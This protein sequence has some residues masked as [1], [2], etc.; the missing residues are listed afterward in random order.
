MLKNQLNHFENSENFE[1][2]NL[3]GFQLKD[4]LLLEEYENQSDEE[5][6]IKTFVRIDNDKVKYFLSQIKTSKFNSENIRKIKRLNHKNILQPLN[7]LLQDN[8]VFIG[9]EFCSISLKNYV[10]TTHPQIEIRLN[11]FSQFLKLVI[12]FIEEKIDFTSADLK[13]FFVENL[14]Q[15]IL[16]VFYHGK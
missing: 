14:N 5:R 16:K 15:P 6:E 9:F 2:F 8:Y 4:S 12:T 11:L 10:S 7:L 1:N 3:E 13:Y